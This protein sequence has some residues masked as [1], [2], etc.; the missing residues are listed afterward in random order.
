M[1]SLVQRLR[2]RRAEHVQRRDND[3]ELKLPKMASLI[4]MIMANVL[5]QVRLVSLEVLS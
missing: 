2:A 5:A 3:P 4:I 1:T